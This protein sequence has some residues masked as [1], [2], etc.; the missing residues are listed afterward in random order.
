MRLSR[1]ARLAAL[2]LFLALPAAEV[3]LRARRGPPPE[4]AGNL[5][6][7]YLALRD[8]MFERDGDVYRSHRM[9]LAPQSFAM[10]KPPD[11][12][13]VFVVGGS[14]AMPYAKPNQPLAR[15]LARALGQPVE[16]IGAGMG[17][18][19][20]A[21]D[22]LVAREVLGYSPDLLVVM[23][24]NNDYHP[25]IPNLT[26]VALQVRLSRF[27]LFRAL[28]AALGTDER[29]L[30]RNVETGAFEENIRALAREARAKG[31]SVVLVTLP[32]NLKDM[33]PTSYGGG[34]P[35][36]NP[37]FAAAWEDYEFGRYAS[38]ARRL[39]AFEAS[40]PL[41]PYSRYY[42]AKALERLGRAAEAGKEYARAADLDR[43][44]QKM[45]P[46]RSELVRRI[47]REE[48]ALVADLEGEFRRLAPMRAPGRE[49]LVDGCHWRPEY[50]RLATA[51]IASAVKPTPELARELAGARHPRL[52]PS[53]SAEADW[54]RAYS[55][56][57]V[58]L[59]SEN[60]EGL[61]EEAVS[62]LQLALTDDPRL[63]YAVT[64]STCTY[65]YLHDRFHAAYSASEPE[66]LRY[67]TLVHA[68]AALR[69]AGKLARSLDYFDQALALEPAGA[70]ARAGRAMTLRRMGRK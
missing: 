11:V 69:R 15:E 52:D 16:V 42:R 48:G 8:P 43:P 21:R 59:L 22:L 17:G 19:D 60:R 39:G 7:F 24:G 3:G 56:V 26:M 23:S 13:R 62:L 32:A 25:P 28:R 50:Y 58:A 54:S 70:L 12:Y 64:G 10:P 41:D 37:L 57:T 2:S 63:F 20:S 36:K 29:A 46:A 44:S 51:V 9:R 30:V 49:L 35:L 55:G 5:D 38:A 1:L 47:A 53:A 67:N 27:W 18:Y 31:V 33:P 45:P 66:R 61:S 40:H 14:V 65:P 4:L 6:Y 34:L 68:G